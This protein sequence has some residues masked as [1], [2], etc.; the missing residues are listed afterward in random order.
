MS[1]QDKRYAAI[2]TCVS[3][4]LDENA[5]WSHAFSREDIAKAIL[6]LTA[7]GRTE[8]WFNAIRA[9]ESLVLDTENDAR[10]ALLQGS[11]MAAHAA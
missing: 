9:W 5:E 11:V 4:F 2:Q 3:S 10:W 6:P 7:L 1:A 8:R